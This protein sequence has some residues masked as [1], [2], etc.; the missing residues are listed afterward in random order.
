VKKPSEL[1]KKGS[2]V[3]ILRVVAKQGGGDEKTGGVSAE[4]V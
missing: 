4:M 1:L 3:S 2:V